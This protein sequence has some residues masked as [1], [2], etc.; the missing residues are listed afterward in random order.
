M[1]SRT[2]FSS[3]RTARRSAALTAVVALAVTTAASVAGARVP[4]AD[5]TGTVVI[6]DNTQVIVTV[7]GPS[8][9]GLVSGQI[10]N[11]SPW[12]MV[13]FAPGAGGAELPNQVTDA[14]VVAEAVSYYQANIFATGG[15]EVPVVGAIDTGSVYDFLPTGSFNKA[16]GRST[17]GFVDLRNA[18]TAARMSGFTGNPYTGTNSANTKITVNAGQ[19]VSWRADLGQPATGARR[20]FQVGALFY[21]TGNGQA[22]LYAGYQDNVVPTEAPP[23]VLPGM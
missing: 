14:R 8:P 13:C 23:R 17:S 16:L 18:Q 21:C 7:S 11:S 3:G 12:Q 15:M 22:Y 5:D 2:T 9:Q 4:G 19:S 1:K 20:S 10:R 6:T